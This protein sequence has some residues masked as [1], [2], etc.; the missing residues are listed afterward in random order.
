MIP[1]G[2]T[3]FS[4]YHII[5]STYH[6]I[7]NTYTLFFSIYAFP[8]SLSYIPYTPSTA[9]ATLYTYLFTTLTTIFAIIVPININ[10]T[11]QLPNNIPIKSKININPT[12][13]TANINIGISLL[14]RKYKST[15]NTVKHS[16]ANIILP[17][18]LIPPKQIYNL[19]GFL[20]KS[21]NT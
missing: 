18:L 2:P 14:W 5:F 12:T 15:V 4:T 21:R 10:S 19:C 17:I 13:T 3:T 6:I 7:F 20:Y 11:G 16:K 8:S 1:V 9:I